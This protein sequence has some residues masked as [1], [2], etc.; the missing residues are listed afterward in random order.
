MF[1]HLF[2]AQENNYAFVLCSRKCL[3]ICSLL[4]KM[5]IH[6]FFAQEN[7]Y[8]FVLCS[9]K[10]LYICSLLKKMFIHLFFAQENVYTFVLCSRKCL[11]ICSFYM[12]SLKYT[13]NLESIV[14]ILNI[15]HLNEIRIISHTYMDSG[16]QTWMQLFWVEQG[17]FG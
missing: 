15:I 2:F 16:Y 6:L 13:P 14:W 4:K 8:T 10:C 17:N 11:Y 7:V 3:Y 1:I 12:I 9:R 5:F